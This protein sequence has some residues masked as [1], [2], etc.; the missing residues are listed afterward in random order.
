MTAVIWWSSRTVLLVRLDG[1]DGCSTNAIVEGLSMPPL[2]IVFKIET[3]E[4]QYVTSR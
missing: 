2:I 4:K 3:K 1:P